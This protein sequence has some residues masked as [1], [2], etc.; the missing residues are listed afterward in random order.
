MS[1]AEIKF[2]AG[3]AVLLLTGPIACQAEKGTVGLL[4][5]ASG[6]VLEH[7][8]VSDN[9]TPILEDSKLE[10]VKGGTA[11]VAFYAKGTT[12]SAS[13]PSSL[14]PAFFAS[15]LTAST[16]KAAT[17]P[18]GALC[19]P[20]TINGIERSTAESGD[21]GTYTFQGPATVE[22]KA[23][24]L[25]FPLGTCTRFENVA[26][27]S[28]G[29]SGILRFSGVAPDEISKRLKAVRAKEIF[30]DRSA[31]IKLYEKMSQDYPSAADWIQRRIAILSGNPAPPK[32]GASPRR[33]ALVIGISEYQWLEKSDYI[34]AARND[35][36]LFYDYLISP[37]G[38]FDPG[39]VTLLLDRFASAEAIRLYFR[40][41]SDDVDSG[42]I[43]YVYI[44]SHSA[45]IGRRDAAL[46][47]YDSRPDVQSTMA[48]FSEIADMLSDIEVMGG[49]VVL[50]AD[51]CHAGLLDNRNPSNQR[52]ISIANDAQFS[53]VVSS[54][55]NQV[56]FEM[57]NLSPGDPHAHGLFTF[58]LVSAL[59][60]SQ[61]P[62]Q[63]LMLGQIAACVKDRIDD[64][65]AAHKTAS[66]TPVPFGNRNT[67]LGDAS[68]PGP[69][70]DSRTPEANPAAARLQQA[71]DVERRAQ[72]TV[73]YYLA[74]EEFDLKAPDF[75]NAANLFEKA[76]EMRPD[77]TSLA[78]RRD[79]CT[80]R[81]ALLA[82]PSLAAASESIALLDQAIVQAPFL[83]YLYNARGIARMT[84]LQYENQP[85]S[86][87]AEIQS[88][89][90]DFEL[91][92]VLD[93]FWAYPRHNLALALRQEGDEPGA[94]RAY[95]QGMQWAAF[96]GLAAGYMAHNLGD[97]Y[98]RQQRWGEALA[99]FQSAE[100]TFHLA[101]F[102]LLGQLGRAAH[103]GD[104][105]GQTW[106]M[107]RVIY[108][109]RAEAEAINGRAA[110]YAF[111]GAYGKAVVEYQRAIGT[112]RGSFETHR[113]LAFL[114]LDHARSIDE[115][116]DALAHLNTNEALAAKDGSRQMEARAA[117]DIGWYFMR[118]GRLN[119]KH[120]A[121]PAADYREAIS[122]FQK[123]QAY[124]PDD[125]RA[126]QGLQEATQALRRN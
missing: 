55:G 75:L 109:K 124:L 41:V 125:P 126:S 69:A 36:N 60:D 3:L 92:I 79:F 112:D 106:A 46:I 43:F 118:R 116:D 81:A 73:L 21:P 47:A 7:V 31:A 8:R 14:I 2:A 105:D 27:L 34:P 25:S 50:F 45:P 20:T 4:T 48:P 33:R 100:D 111:D 28:R 23:Q 1:L 61:K 97:L 74:G 101:R 72:E 103:D 6:A 44:A 65:A 58:S 68:R 39:D 24:K 40:Q 114:V 9:Q 18:A 110:T 11:K 38:G 84:R 98:V 71:A 12:A 49:N 122:H 70:N 107:Q 30:G 29:I 119:E 77:D 37:R 120:G 63:S 121:S 56:S 108:F 66:Q 76:W 54:E 59:A 91:A 123:A 115:L 42:D 85:K 94:E 15:W 117:S 62:C 19:S 95:K 35:A 5:N 13:W 96:Y 53:G 16:V 87:R 64:Y 113:N 99:Q 90:R 78:V 26:P 88:A 32:D 102:Q 57:T 104:S 86:A 80:A 52:L 67:I 83:S 82:R 89:E 93:P 51:I 22:I 17:V 10:L